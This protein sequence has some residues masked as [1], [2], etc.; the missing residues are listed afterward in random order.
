M[1]L[2]IGRFN[3]LTTVRYLLEVVF[4]AMDT[5]FGPYFYFCLELALET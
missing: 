1:E 3:S 2:T 5:Y 4:Q